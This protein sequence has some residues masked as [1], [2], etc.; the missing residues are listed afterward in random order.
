MLGE[1]EMPERAE[2]EEFEQDIKNNVVI[3]I[4]NIFFIIMFLILIHKSP[5][6]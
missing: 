2:F 6:C 5:I 3:K 1:S 4:Q